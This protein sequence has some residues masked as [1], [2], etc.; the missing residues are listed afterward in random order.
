M[1]Q[2]N[3]EDILGDYFAFR[4]WFFLLKVK[5][6]RIG[7]DPKRWMENGINYFLDSSMLENFLDT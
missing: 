4:V 1:I 6:T 2:M 3:R 5:F 7:S